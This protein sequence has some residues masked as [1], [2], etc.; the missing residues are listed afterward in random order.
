MF[1]ANTPEPPYYA[2]IFTSDRNEADA[3]GY[4]STADFMVEL[5]AQQE[6]FLGVESV[7][8]QDGIGITVSYWKSLDSI[9]RWK[10]NSLHKKAQEKGKKDWYS[11][12]FTRIC[13]V[14][15]DYHN[16]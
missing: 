8:D 16:K 5:A 10:E 13:K 14:E 1:F 2:C 3:A 9:K 4:N 12:Y 11:S 7:R 6:G 15:R